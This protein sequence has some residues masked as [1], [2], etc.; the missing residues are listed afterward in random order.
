MLTMS[1][2]YAVIGN[3]IKHSKS[4]FIHAEFATQT[5]QDLSY[6]AECVATG[7]VSAF[8][9]QFKNNNGKGLN[10]TVPFKQDAFALADI[11]SERA[12]RAGAVN[13]L[14][15]DNKI[16]GD[17]TDG[18]GL[19]NDLVRHHNIELNHKRL[20]ILGA[21]GAVRGVIE[22]LL[23]HRP[24][25]LII[26]NRTVEKALTLKGIFSALGSVDACGFNELG[27]EKFDL[28]ING[29]SASLS[30]ELPPMPNN[31]LATHASVYDMMYATKPTPFMLWGQQQGAELC[32]DGLGML[33]EQAAESF[34]IWRG[35]RPETKSVIKNL[36]R[37][38]NKQ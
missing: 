13:T 9:D 29:T 25:Q 2:R 8:I 27:N 35:V 36:R 37:I 30:G 12:Q 38:L 6:T 18:T 21:G 28:I 26:A 23:E 31:V 14:S 11:L 16:R 34:Y 3:P 4:P 19:V 5:Q 7:K 1:D 33:V 10:V 20:L 24:G 17:T 15:L 32:L 22:S